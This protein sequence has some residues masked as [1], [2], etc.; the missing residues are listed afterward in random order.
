MK[1]DGAEV[2]VSAKVPRS[3]L[4]GLLRGKVW[5][6]DDFNEPLENITQ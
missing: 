4:K 5:M 2:T 6:S 1:I 3:S